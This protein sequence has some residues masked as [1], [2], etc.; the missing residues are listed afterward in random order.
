VAPLL[1]R[2]P[3]L[4]IEIPSQTKPLRNYMSRIFSWE[5]FRSSLTEAERELGDEQV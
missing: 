2:L 1:W 3:S 5:S 4:G